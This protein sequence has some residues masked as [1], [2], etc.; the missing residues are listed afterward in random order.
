MVLSAFSNGYFCPSVFRLFFRFI[1][2]SAMPASEGAGLLT[3][4]DN[5]QMDICN[6][7]SVPTGVPTGGYSNQM[8]VCAT[9]SPRDGDQTGGYSSQMDICTTPS[10]IRRQ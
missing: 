3:D 9:S 1:V 5:D 4:G 8:D 10:P 6:E 2:A 7:A